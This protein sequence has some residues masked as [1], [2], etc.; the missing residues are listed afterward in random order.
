M[1]L[2]TAL[3]ASAVLITTAAHSAQI[4]QDNLINTGISRPAPQ[5]AF[6]RPGGSYSSQVI[7]AHNTRM[8]RIRTMTGAVSRALLRFARR[9]AMAIG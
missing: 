8:I 2:T 1:S 9:R 4:G 5:R 7:I 3:I 6:P